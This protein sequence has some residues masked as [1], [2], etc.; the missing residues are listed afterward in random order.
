MT[1]KPQNPNAG[2]PLPDYPAAY[3][4]AKRLQSSAGIVKPRKSASIERKYGLLSS[5][6]VRKWPFTKPLLNPSSL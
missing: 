1:T 4:A 6:R 3:L 2:L 5:H